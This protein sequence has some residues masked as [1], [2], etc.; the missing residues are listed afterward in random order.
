[1][2]VHNTETKRRRRSILAPKKRSDVMSEAG[3][4]GEG[5]KSGRFI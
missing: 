1:M 2:M 4:E 3:I 5:P